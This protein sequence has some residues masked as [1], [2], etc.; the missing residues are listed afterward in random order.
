MFNRKVTY[1]TRNMSALA[2]PFLAV[3]RTSEAARRAKGSTYPA[4]EIFTLQF[5]GAVL[6]MLYYSET[7]V[8]GINDQP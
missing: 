7:V 6:V 4:K 2:W 8:V 5:V 1:S 3:F